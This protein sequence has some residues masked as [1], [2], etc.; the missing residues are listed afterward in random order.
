MS[1]CPSFSRIMVKGD[2]WDTDAI[3]HKAMN[4]V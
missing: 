2:T 4:A 1:D 3:F